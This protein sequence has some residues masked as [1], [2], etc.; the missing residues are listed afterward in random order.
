MS[1]SHR[2]KVLL[3]EE[4]IT[5]SAFCSYIEFS[6]RNLSHFLKGR[7]EYPR[8][9]FVMKTMKHRPDWSWR[10]IF[11][12]E[13]EKYG[14]ASSFHTLEE[15]IVSYNLDQSN[16]IKSLARQLDYMREENLCLRRK[17]DDLE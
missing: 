7:T 14:T 16:V 13:G 4:G 6:V 1:I 2:F 10:W 9:D 5:Q 11:F 3:A 15:P 12:G 8:M 17:L